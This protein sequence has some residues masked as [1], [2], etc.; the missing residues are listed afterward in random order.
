MDKSDVSSLLGELTPKTEYAEF[1]ELWPAIQKAL[2]RQN[3]LNA[4]HKALTDAGA[5]SISYVTFTRFVKK[6][7]AESDSGN[8]P[9]VQSMPAKRA[10][11]VQATEATQEKADNPPPV[12]SSEPED[13]SGIVA[14]TSASALTEA[15]ETSK[16]NYAANVRRRN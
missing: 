3:R 4:I 13:K 7:Q 5:L 2:D 8:L 10:N 9:G 15:R 11:T 1:L 6:R 14:T 16:K 12:V